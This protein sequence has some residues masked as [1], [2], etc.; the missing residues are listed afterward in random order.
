[1]WH[2]A[3]WRELLAVT[4]R[5]R[6]AHALLLH[7]PGGWGKR[8]FARQFA[9][10]LLEL[11]RG[12]AE[13]VC[14]GEEGSDADLLSHPDAR[15]VAREPAPSSGRLRAQI[16]VDQIRALTGFLERTSSAGGRRVVV[17]ERAEELN[18]NAAN[19]LLK[20]LE[21]PG[22]DTHLLLVCDAPSRLLA[23]IRSRCQLH[24]LPPAEPSV[25][26]DWLAAR[27]PE[28]VDVDST[29]ALAGGAPLLALD[30][31][32]NDA[33][34]LAATVE[35]FL[36]DG[37][38]RDLVDVPGRPDPDAQRARAAAVLVFLYRALARRIRAGAGG[39]AT[40]ADQRVL[41]RVLEARRMLES[42]ANPNVTLL[43]E[44]LLLPIGRSRRGRG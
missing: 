15:I 13:A 11:P 5:G 31:L 1:P 40:L 43:L 42:T 25:A 7:G 37:D 26:R 38:P 2:L 8:V 10:A 36:E 28:G 22:P 30:Q 6:L 9:R 17:L 21:E 4:E 23:T 32:A 3:P 12:G 16:T 18:V 29:L 34:E 19:A 39:P 24:A 14:P 33:A 20:S 27:L 35:A 41:G 44:D